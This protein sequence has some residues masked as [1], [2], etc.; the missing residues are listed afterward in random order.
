VHLDEEQ[1]QR[2]LHGELSPRVE[3]SAREHV[4]GCGDCRRHLAEAEREESEVLAL[5]RAVDDPLPL[6]TSAGGVAAMAELA[7][8]PAHARDLAWFRRA[9]GIIVAVG[10]AGAAYAVPGS[11]VRGWV[12]AIVQK[13]GGRPETSGVAPAPGGSPA[14]G[15]GI[16]VLPEQK[17]LI[18]FK[19][20]Q[21]DGQV[22]VSLTDGTEV[23]VHAP[24]GAATFTSGVGQLVID[25]RDP[26]ATFEIEIPG[27]APWV[28]IQ[29]GTDRIFLKEGARVT[30]SGSKRAVGGYLLRFA[31]SGS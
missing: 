10:I 22:F 28:E 5:L 16:S 21:G 23:Q 20:D 24:T 25:V 18:L 30:T 14:Q 31:P 15:S 1:V 6:R 2:L 4:A 3:R 11:P 12:H 27:S 26:S 29:A 9:A 7:S 8:A 19:S 17:L 13:L